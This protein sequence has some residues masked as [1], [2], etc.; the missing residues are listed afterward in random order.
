MAVACGLR[1]R[2]RAAAPRVAAAARAVAYAVDTTVAAPGQARALARAPAAR[3]ARRLRPLG[4]GLVEHDGEVVLAPASGREDD[5][6][7]RCGRPAAVRA[8]LPL[9]PVTLE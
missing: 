3:G 7:C 9:S 8:G 5:P 2:R 6:S 1:R 4:H